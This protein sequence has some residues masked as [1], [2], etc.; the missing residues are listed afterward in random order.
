MRSRDSLQQDVTG[1]A[2][3]RSLSHL[4]MSKNPE[5]K[6][7]R[8]SWQEHDVWYVVDR[9]QEEYWRKAWRVVQEVVTACK[10]EVTPS[11]GREKLLEAARKKMGAR[12]SNEVK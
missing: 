10:S 8:S 7:L 3:K 12:S 2:P 4:I 6:S 9:L 5:R 1:M 11:E